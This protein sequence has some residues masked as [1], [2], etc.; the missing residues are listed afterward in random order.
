MIP[1]D[2]VKREYYVNRVDTNFYRIGIQEPLGTVAPGA[3]VSAT[4]RLFAGPQQARMLESITPGLDLVK[5]YGWLTIV[6]KPLFWLLE[7]FTHCW[8]TGAG[9]S[10]HSPC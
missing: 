6:A 7:R 1:A 2:N 9:R 8:A 10:L 5:D 4:A 3:S